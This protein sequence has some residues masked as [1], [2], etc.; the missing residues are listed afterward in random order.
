MGS[1]RIGI[2]GG[3]IVGL[4][5]AYK[6]SQKYPQAQVILFEKENKLAEHQTGR[7]SGVIHSGIYYKPGSLKAKTCR[8]GKQQLETFCAQHNVA[9]ETCGKVIVALNE[10]EKQSLYNIYQRGQENQVNCRL[11]SQSELKEIEPHVNGI[12]AIHVKETGIADYVG[13]CE[14][15]SHLLTESGHLIKVNSKVTEILKNNEGITL[16]TSQGE[17]RVDYLV[18]CA[19][20][21]SD[22]VAR[23][24]GLN[25]SVKIIPFRGEYFELT[26]EAEHLCQTLIYPVPDP[27]FPFLGVHFTRMVLGGVECGPNA[28]LAFAREGYDNK[29]IN[30]GEFAETLTYPGFIKL[31]SKFWRI[32]LGEMH[33]SYSK[34]AFVT[35]LQRLVPEV[36][37]DHLIQAP[38]G[39][40]A[41]AV[42]ANGAMVDDFA[43]VEDQRSVHVINAPSPAATACLA[44]AD[45]ILAMLSPKIS[46]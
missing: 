12:E 36:K 3:G 32:G 25:P 2:I 29:T 45:E 17:E 34:K 30:V 18:N 37:E 5:T 46:H 44:I 6:V 13:F 26:K 41:Q 42:N 15:I 4:S 27:K 39:V 33:R 8:D 9:F 16:I 22:K 7:N 43:F 20:L 40:R 19:G 38:A 21:Q 35:A 1:F 24:A 14:T 28:V 10:G 11:I 23:M 31:A